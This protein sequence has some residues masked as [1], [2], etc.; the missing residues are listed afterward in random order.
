MRLQR[1]FVLFAL[2]I[3]TACQRETP[4]SKL[5]VAKAKR[6]LGTIS[7]PRLVPGEDGV[8]F[9][10]DDPIDVLVRDAVARREFSAVSAKAN[11]L[12]TQQ[13]DDD[14]A[15]DLGQLYN[16]FTALGEEES[17]ESVERA[18]S[19]WV[20]SEPS[21]HI[22]LTARGFLYA[23]RAWKARGSGWSNEV[24]AGGR[25]DFE[26]F[27]TLARADFEKARSLQPRD[28]NP[29]AGLMLV[30]LGTG[31]SRASMERDY[32]MALSAAPGHY[33][34]RNT[35]LQ[36]LKPKWFGSEEEMLDFAFSCTREAKKHPY[37]AFM[38]ADALQ[39][40]HQFP[41]TMLRRKGVLAALVGRSNRPPAEYLSYEAPWRR[42]SDAYEIF[43]AAHPDNL[44]V[45]FWYADAAYRARQVDVFVEQAEAIGDRWLATTDWSSETAY[46]KAAA[47]AYRMYAF[48][49]ELPPREHVYFTR[50]AVALDPDDAEVRYSH[51]VTLHQLDRFDE[52]A[53]QYRRAMQL[54]PKY[55]RPYAGLIALM[56][57]MNQCAEVMRLRS[58]ARNI[59][60]E[61]EDVQMVEAAVRYCSR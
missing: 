4:L 14:R 12:L 8:V 56:H 46:R 3:A 29:S 27:L 51:A 61:G 49:K 32:R 40:E 45:R 31:A 24:T 22:A 2:V 48:K 35:M 57:R 1:P 13:N 6:S 11:A 55:P 52:A 38:E 47:V 26:R 33:G 15:F 36:Y 54:D 7:L 17:A 19:S 30:G 16:I 5:P 9:R 59:A 50:R 41:G 60:F 18:V 58:V 28:P 10:A 25:R 39:E 34:A 37:A 53:V 42:V 23:G 21:S 43:L 20:S 44:R